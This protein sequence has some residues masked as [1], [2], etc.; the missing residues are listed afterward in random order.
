VNIPDPCPAA[1]QESPLVGQPRE[2]TFASRKRV[3]A[4]TMRT[5][6]LDNHGLK[7]YLKRSLLPS[8]RK[9][10]I[11]RTGLLSGLKVEIDFAHQTQRW[12]GLQERELY[13]WFRRLTEGIRMAVDVGAADG[14]YTL[15]FLAKTSAEKVLA[16]EPSADSL[17]QLRNNL[18]LNGLSENPRLEIVPKFVGASANGIEATLDSFAGRIQT[19]CLIKVDI[20]GGEVSLLNGARTLLQSGG[21]CWIIEVHSRALQQ[22]CLEVLQKAGYHAVVV[23][24]AWWRHLLPELRPIELNDWIVAIPRPVP[25]GPYS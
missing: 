20:D 6:H 4:N 13:P 23:P 1:Y 2:K 3:K 15:Y 7:Y 21:I 18:A 25:P 17:S 19:P 12:L 9:P 11:I 16:F 24:N 5:G 8:G 14:M 10:R 22:N